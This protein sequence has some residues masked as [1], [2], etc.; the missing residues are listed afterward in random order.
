MKKDLKRKFKQAVKESRPEQEIGKMRQ[1]FLI[2]KM[3]RLHNKVRK[4]ELKQREKRDG[5]KTQN[6]FKENPHKYAKDLFNE[7][8][9]SPNSAR[10]LPTNFSR[11]LT[12]MVT[13]NS[14]MIL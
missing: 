14:D 2:K 12:E 4:L 1:N 9:V 5:D 13:A 8:R 3:I 10:K 7:K 11:Q 6:R